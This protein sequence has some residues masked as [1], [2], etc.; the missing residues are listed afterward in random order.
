MAASKPLLKRANRTPFSPLFRRE[1]LCYCTEELGSESI[2]CRT[3]TTEIADC[4]NMESQ[5]HHGS[6]QAACRYHGRKAPSRADSKAT[7]PVDACASGKPL[8]FLDEMV[9]EYCSQAASKGG[10][11]HQH[12]RSFPPSISSLSSGRPIMRS[13]KSNG[14]F[15]LQRV[16]TPKSPFCAVRGNG[17]LRLILDSTSSATGLDCDGERHHASSHKASVGAFPGEGC[18][19]QSKAAVQRQIRASSSD[20]M[21]AHASTS[22]LYSFKYGGVKANL[23]RVP[24]SVKMF[25]G[26]GGAPCSVCLPATLKLLLE[27]AQKLSLQ[28]LQASHMHDTSG[29]CYISASE[30]KDVQGFQCEGADNAKLH[31]VKKS[32]AGPCPLIRSAAST[33][34]ALPLLGIKKAGTQLGSPGVLSIRS[35]AA[36]STQLGA[37]L[38]VTGNPVHDM[39]SSIADVGAKREH[40][41]AVLSLSLNGLILI[42]MVEGTDTSMMTIKGIDVS[43]YLSVP[44]STIASRCLYRAQQATARHNYEQNA[45]DHRLQLL[46]SCPERTLEPASLYHT[47][48]TSKPI[49]FRIAA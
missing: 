49:D 40:G 45:V 47:W 13:F 41:Y 30:G 48:H 36:T 10:M 24:R 42:V 1:D 37:A 2:S 14:R 20:T 22:M 21:G 28:K 31:K 43:D 9:P 16:D 5:G 38:S 29:S 39:S 33:S 23:V 17:R 11:S 46:T 34:S 8:H 12:V 19:G 25:N 18:D 35:N 3:S 7:L 6:L 26:R 44:P 27:R 32:N 15:V 4:A